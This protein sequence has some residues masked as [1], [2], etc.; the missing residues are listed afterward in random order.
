M[1]SHSVDVPDTNPTDQFVFE[2]DQVKERPPWKFCS[3]SIPRSEIVF[4]TQYSIIFLLI[5]VCIYKLCAS[6]LSCEDSKFWSS[7]LTSLVGYILP[8]PSL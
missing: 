5:S 3:N 8:N 6:E 2:R 1:E 4:F 7:L